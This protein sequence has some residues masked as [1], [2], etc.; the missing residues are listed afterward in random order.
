MKNVTKIILVL[1]TLLTLCGFIGCA[2]STGE[3]DGIHKDYDLTG[4]YQLPKFNITISIKA[5]GD[6]TYEDDYSK[7]SG[8]IKK[9]IAIPTFYK[10]ISNDTT[11]TYTTEEIEIPEGYNYYKFEG[12]ITEKAT[13]ETHNT[14]C[15]Y[16]LKKHDNSL[17][18][19]Q[20][21]H[22][23]DDDN[24]NNLYLNSEEVS[25]PFMIYTREG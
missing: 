4:V 12:E 25:N 18:Q 24:N 8:K 3:S 17:I 9:D 23:S 22:N 16:L 20:I 21:M 19:I 14:Y 13:N 15:Y 5:N 6:F 11:Y 2:Q 10:R 7:H 1:F